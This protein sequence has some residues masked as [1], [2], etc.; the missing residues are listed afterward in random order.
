M[1]KNIH[2]RHIVAAVF[3]FMFFAVVEDIASAYAKTH[4]SPAATQPA[5]R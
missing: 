5:N 4:T 2:G 3:I 1:F